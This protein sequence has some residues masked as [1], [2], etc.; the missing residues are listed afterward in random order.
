MLTLLSQEYRDGVLVYAPESNFLVEPATSWL[1]AVRLTVQKLVF[2]FTPWLPHYSAAHTVM[3]LALFVPAY[4]L[5]IA[6]IVNLRRLA[7]PQQRAAWLLTLYLLCV[8][9]FHAMMQIEYDHRYRLPMLPALIMLATIGLES[10][11]RP[12]TLASIARTR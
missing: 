6:A 10:V 12:R 1:G 7:P 11:R 4:G 2:V 5:S 8:P 9:V 3:N